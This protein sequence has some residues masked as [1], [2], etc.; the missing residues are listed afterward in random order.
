MALHKDLHALF[1]AGLI[2]VT[3]DARLAVSDLLKS[4]TYRA[5][6]GR[7]VRFPTNPSCHPS[8]EA[9]ALHRKS[10]RGSLL[11]FSDDDNTP[12]RTTS[13]VAVN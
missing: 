3:E 11:S 5:L 10:V 6:H 4:K 8:P 7:A 12:R 2:T 1:D 13:A 9:L